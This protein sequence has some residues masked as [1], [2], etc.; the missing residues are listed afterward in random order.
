P[1]TPEGYFPS[2]GS[3]RR[4]H[5]RTVTPVFPRVRQQAGPYNLTHLSVTDALSDV[6]SPSAGN[7][8]FMTASRHDMTENMAWLVC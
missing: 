6:P 1:V 4:P 3:C 2:G 7:E 8:R 5:C